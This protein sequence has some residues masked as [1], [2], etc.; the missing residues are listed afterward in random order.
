MLQLHSVKQEDNFCG[1][2]IGGCVFV[3]VCVGGGGWG[4]GGLINQI[5]SI[6]LKVLGVF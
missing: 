3:C 6:R 1:S 5:F 4:V 2:V